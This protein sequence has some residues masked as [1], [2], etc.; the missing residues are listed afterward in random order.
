VAQITADQRARLL[1][2]CVVILVT[3]GSMM[4]FDR[5]ISGMDGWA[6]QHPDEDVLAQIGG[7][8]YL[9]TK[10][11]WTRVLPPGEFREAVRAAS[12]MVA[13]AGMGS[14][15]VAMEMQK[16]IVMLPRI[17]ASREHTTDHQLHTLQWLRDRPGVYAAMSAEQLT[18]AIDAAL[19]E[20]NAAIGKLNCF[21]PESFL[22]DVRRFLTE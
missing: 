21:A 17:A 7:G 4:P 3:V 11:R 15:F 8:S 1:G 10:M 20:G 2:I 6:R 14:F 19:N 12:I 22:T 13:H 5:L 9:P 16:P 18:P